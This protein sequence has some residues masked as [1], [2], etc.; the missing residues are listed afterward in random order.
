MGLEWTT[1]RQ[2]AA[3]KALAGGCFP[4]YVGGVSVASD[5]VLAFLCKI[6]QGRGD[7]YFVINNFWC[8]SRVAI[9]IGLDCR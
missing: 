3:S 5:A 1:A 7:K 6:Q 2:A 8:L 4:V 9:F